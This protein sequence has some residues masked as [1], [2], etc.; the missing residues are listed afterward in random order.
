MQTSTDHIR[1]PG[2]ERRHHRVLVT[3]NSEYHCRDGV[4]VAVR[5][6]STHRFVAEHPAL[7]KRISGGLRFND[8]GGIDSITQDSE[9]KLGEQVCF[10]A[11]GEERTII[12]SPLSA[13]ER[14][15]KDV[16]ARYRH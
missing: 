5:D 15:P 2:P 1:Y 10:T 12:T 16:V 13:I 14:P 3:R 9:V 4:C 8:N 7:G 11:D 6:R